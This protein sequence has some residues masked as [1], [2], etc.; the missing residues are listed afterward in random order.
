[1]TSTSTFVF[2]PPAIP[3]V[4]VLGCAERFPLH[5]IYCVGR[6]YAEHAREMGAE[7][8]KGRPVFFMKPA[9]AV[10][11]DGADVAWP[12]ATANL[13]HEVEL[14]IALG[15]GGRPQTA[16]EAMALVYGYAVGNDL[17]RRDLQHEC[18]AKGLP[19]DIAKG[20]DQSAP[21]SPIRPWPASAPPPSRGA[22]TLAVNGQVRQ[23]AD[24]AE[25]IWSLPEIL[26]EL[27]KLY[28]L[29]AGDLVFTGTPAGVGPLTIGDLVH[30][31]IAGV[32]TLTHRMV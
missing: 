3:S 8:D 12:G 15:A 24:L 10:V 4:P 7:I 31:E 32:G 1:M 23:Q 20:F 25:L 14:V 26:I 29:R 30:A 5:R 19:W 13:H 9:D 21:V 16:A 27:G 6:N 11:C 22:I 17:T 2:S 28:M 18:K